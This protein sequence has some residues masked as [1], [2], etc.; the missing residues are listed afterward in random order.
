MHALL[1]VCIHRMIFNHNK[2]IK[3]RILLSGKENQSCD[4]QSIIEI[5]FREREIN[6]VVLLCS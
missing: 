3:K 5:K 2:G 4:K 1:E 6:D